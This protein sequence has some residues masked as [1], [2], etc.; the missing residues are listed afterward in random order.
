LYV[1]KSKPSELEIEGRTIKVSNLDKV[2]YP[3]ARF[4]TGQVIDYYMRVSD[5]LLPHL[6]DRPVTLKRYPDGMHGEFFYEKD[7]PAFAPDWVS[8][9]PVPRH[10]GGTDICYI[11]INDLP[12]L[13]WCANLA[14]L[15]LHPFL[16]RISP[17]A[18]PGTR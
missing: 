5:F 7:A 6:K 10:A 9:F 12:T 13:V 3:A 1:A 15:E 4:T 14:S 16:H 2:L 8:K 17:T 11:L 18:R